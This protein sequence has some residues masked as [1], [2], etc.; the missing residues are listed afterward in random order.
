MF[1]G[2]EEALGWIH[3]RLKFGVKP[4]IERMKW[5]ME[6]LDHPE[7]K[8]KAIHIAGTNGKGSTV[9]FI[10]S[11]LNE[12]GYRVGT[13]TSPYIVTFN[14]RISIN[15]QPISDEEWLFLVNQ[16]KPLTEEL[17]ETELG[18]PT[19]F[20]IITAC[21]FL[22]FSTCKNLDFVIFETGLGGRLDSTNVVEPILTLITTIGHDHMAVLGS[23]LEEIAAEKAGIIKK[24]VPVITAVHQ[25]NA[26]EVIRIKAGEMNAENISLHDSCAIFNEKA[27]SAGEE[28]SLETQAKLYENLQTSLI[29]SHQRQNASLAVLAAENLNQSGLAV[30]NECQIRD[31]LRK[32]VWPGR[33]EKISDDPPVYIDGAHNMEGVERL[34]DTVMDH[35]SGKHLYICFSALKDKPYEK[36]IDKLDKMAYGIHFTSFEF[37]RAEHAKELYQTSSSSNKSWGSQLS[38]INE[39][40]EKCKYDKN[41]VVILT[42]SLYF[43]SQARTMLKK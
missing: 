1:T 18:A 3:G 41:S 39:F 14:E 9:A 27:L 19:E 8:I 15:G 11:I 43:I 29:G 2:F 7:K 20:E 22:Y 32:A 25:K 26:N 17:E 13:F 16:I 30:I 24:N 5:F 33:F 35:F 34:V 4:G 37:P 6:K 38:S 31:G 28:F 10:R 21:A 40:I 42:G 12:S 23:T 36:M